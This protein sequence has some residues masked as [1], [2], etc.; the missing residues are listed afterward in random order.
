MS[1]VHV[2]DPSAAEPTAA[3]GD[4]HDRRL[5][6]ACVR[7][8]ASAFERL[9]REEGE[10]MKRI[11]FG[12]L[13]DSAA[14]EDAVQETFLKVHRSAGSWNGEASFLTWTYRILI[15]TCHDLLR[16]RRRRPEEVSMDSLRGSE[17][18]SAAHQLWLRFTLQKLLADL[19]AQRQ[20]VF[21]LF[22][23]EGMS[24]REIA[25]I[26]GI[27]ESYSKWLLFA[28]RRHLQQMWYEAEEE[29]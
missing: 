8:E 26:L 9:Y 4:P 24:H 7:G 20:S 3:G 13:G 10:R 5:A 17:A 12:H 27:R 6:E 16:Q 15:N 1:L 19:P 22:E 11:A 23:V 25:Q 14:A 29:R 28:T 18:G 21:L 2:I